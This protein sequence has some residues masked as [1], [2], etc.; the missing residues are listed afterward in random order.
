MQRE[1]HFGT[2]RAISS[3]S[4]KP[5]LNLALIRA[6]LNGWSSKL[7][8]RDRLH[9][10]PA[11]RSGVE[12]GETPQEPVSCCNQAC[13]AQRFLSSPR[14]W[15]QLQRQRSRRVRRRVRRRGTSRTWAAGGTCA[16]S[17]GCSAS[18]PSPTS[19]RATRRRA[20]RRAASTESGCSQGHIR[21]ASGAT[22]A[23]RC[24]TAARASFRWRRAAAEGRR[25]EQLSLRHKRD[26][27][28]KVEADQALPTHATRSSGTPTPR[29]RAAAGSVRPCG[30]GKSAWPGVATAQHQQGG[31]GS[32]LAQRG[33]CQ[34]TRQRRAQCACAGTIDIPRA[35]LRSRMAAASVAADRHRLARTHVLAVCVR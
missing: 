35:V 10:Q 3:S 26:D 30:A 32:H 15:R 14:G 31:G 18:S 22:G 33:L 11:A 4:W 1:A 7:V 16:T 25:N 13:E 23:P 19:G 28:S 6:I 34:Q 27:N 17:G 5:H 12:S 21:A 2:L 29:G 8:A 9:A 20:A 24:A